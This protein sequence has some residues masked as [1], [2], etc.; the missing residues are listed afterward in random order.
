MEPPHDKWGAE[1][2][3]YCFSKDWIYSM[4]NVHQ[5]QTQ[6]GLNA[7]MLYLSV[8]F[9]KMNCIVAEWLVQ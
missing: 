6:W 1:K 2:D 8:T 5:M 9:T 7:H 3:S 4:S